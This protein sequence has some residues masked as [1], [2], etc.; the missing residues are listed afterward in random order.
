MMRFLV[1][2]ALLATALAVNYDGYKVFRVTPKDR[3]QLEKL[4]VLK[5][6]L[7][8]YVNFWKEPADVDRPVDMLVS[9]EYQDLVLGLVNGR[10]LDVEV[11][12]D[13]LQ[14]D[15]D[16][17]R[18]GTTATFSYTQFNTL[19]LIEGWMNDLAAQYSS[20]VSVVTVGSSYEGRDIKALKIGTNQFSNSKRSVWYEG[21]IHAREWISPATMI[22]MT[23]LLLDGYD[24]NDQDATTM[25]EELH[26]YILP[27]YNVDGYE[28]TWTSD[29]M[30]RKTRSPNSASTCVGTDPNRNWDYEWVAK[31]SKCSESYP[32][33]HPWS[34]IEV[35]T[36]T[37]YITNLNSVE[38]FIDFHAYGEMWMTPWGYTESLPTDYT[39]QKSVSDSAVSAMGNRSYKTGS[40]A[41]VI[42]QAYGSSVDWTYGALGIVHSYAVE[43]RG[44]SFVISPTQIDDSGIETYEALKYVSLYAI[45][46][47]SR[48]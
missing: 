19:D 39:V 42:Y 20:I 26:T 6:V 41:N 34:E 10:D 32:G 18:A 24:S 35:E 3:L 45:Q 46:N 25:I 13:D 29:R 30:W 21:G 28:F 2:T 44:T 11:T 37:D 12:V 31:V 4:V 40:I 14:T 43:L 23:K 17:E 15:I 48:K 16:E 7:G 27:V 33:T 47:P 8:N 38:A 9:P 1:F 22:Y 36:V 5:S